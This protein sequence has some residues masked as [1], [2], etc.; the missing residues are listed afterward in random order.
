VL[1]AVFQLPAAIGQIVGLILGGVF[2]LVCAVLPL[3]LVR[4]RVDRLG[5][6]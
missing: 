5:E 1:G 3:W 6:N 4:A 2:S